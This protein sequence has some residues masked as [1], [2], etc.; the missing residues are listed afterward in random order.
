MIEKLHTYG[1]TA[2]RYRV[3]WVAREPVPQSAGSAPT[4]ARDPLQ[5]EESAENVFSF[6]LLLPPSRRPSTF[7]SLRYLP[8]VEI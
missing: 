2:T 8:P 5:F 1:I 6:V 3:P 7:P 4:R